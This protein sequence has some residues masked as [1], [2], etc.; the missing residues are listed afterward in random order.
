MASEIELPSVAAGV[1]H[2]TLVRWLKAEGD[3][4]VKGETIAEFETDKA[5]MEMEAESDGTIGR[6]VV[7]A[8]TENVRVGTVIGVLLGPDEDAIALEDHPGL[9]HQ[10]ETDNDNFEK[11]AVHDAAPT[12]AGYSRIDGQ[13][14]RRVFASPLARR[15]AN[16][17]QLELASL[18]GSGP[19]GRVVR[20]DVEQALHRVTRTPF[21]GTETADVNESPCIERIANDS[22]RKTIAH[23]L[24]KSKQEIPHFY[25]TIDCRVDELLELRSRLNEQGSKANAPYRL[26]VNDVLVYAVAKAMRKV[27]EI[28]ASWTESDTLRYHDIDI[29][30][31]VAT[32]KGLVTPII[33]ETDRK[34]L[35]EISNE[36]RE[37]TTKAREGGL[38]PSDYQGGGFTISNLG[39]Y[40]IR[41]FA[42][43]INP[44]QSAILAV[45]AVEKRPLVENEQL[46]IGSVMT[47][48]LSADHRVID[49][50]IG[51][52]FLSELQLLLE[53][54]INLLV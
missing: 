10:E 28:N 50:V 54:P 23:R 26:S 25:L 34:G 33:R 49:G 27:P 43:I 13:G 30:V 16:E 6:I 1:E 35:A 20:I 19:H 36:I 38:A 22:M 44:P 47:M 29:S 11:N 18:S 40:G 39:M 2:A 12:I 51:A 15:L 32:G 45:G 8:G 5:V 41:E 14:K 46:T 17:N 9:D 24:C 7:P 37:L 48:T 4:V 53:S 31:A 52:R 3:S 21:T 42:A